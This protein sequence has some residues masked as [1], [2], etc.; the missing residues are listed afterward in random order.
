MN[1]T[2]RYFVFLILLNSCSLDTKSG[3]WTDK[4]K[5][6]AEVDTSIQV[7]AKSELLDK[8]FNSNLKI[9]LTSKLVNNSFINNL[10]N[11]NGRINYDGELKSAFLYTIRCFISL[12]RFVSFIN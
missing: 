4:K 1:N 3:I 2:F 6:K 9:K 8:E 7:F 11:N 12:S 5:L 10:T